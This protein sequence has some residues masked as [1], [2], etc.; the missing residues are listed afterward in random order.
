VS[1]RERNRPPPRWE[2]LLRLHPLAAM[3]GARAPGVEGVG[4][5]GE[6]EDDGHVA[7][8]VRGALPCV[9]LPAVVR[10]RGADVRQSK[11]RRLGQVRSA[12]LRAGHRDAWRE[13]EREEPQRLLSLLRRTDGAGAATGIGGAATATMRAAW[14]RGAE[15]EA[16]LRPEGTAT[17]EEAARRA[18][19][20]RGAPTARSD[21]E[22]AISR[23]RHSLAS[24]T[25]CDARRRLTHT[26]RR[27]NTYCEFGTTPPVAW[28]V[29]AS[30]L[31]WRRR[32]VVS[33]VGDVLTCSESQCRG[34][35]CARR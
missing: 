19:T 20:A 4:G 23:M 18:A 11:G 21:M 16:A 3:L 26:S 29:S 27:S 31:P 7:H 13:V 1:G 28:R 30:Q 5:C 24:R 17:R 10:D 34:R 15:R 2:S 12:S 8:Q 35:G 33:R 14:A 9:A 32:S 6:A 22:T 25:A